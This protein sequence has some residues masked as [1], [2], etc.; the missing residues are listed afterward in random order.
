MYPS[1]NRDAAVFDDPDRFDVRRDPNPHLAFGFGPH[2]CLGASLARLELKV[3]FAELLRRLPD[4]AA[5]RR[6]ARPA[7]RRTSSRAPKRCRSR[8]PRHNYSGWK[9]AIVLPS[10]SLNQAE[11]PMP[12]EVTTWSTVLNVPVSY[13]SN[14]MP[15]RGELG[16]VLVDVGRPE[17]HLGVVGPVAARRGRRSAGSCRRRSRR[18]GGS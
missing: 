2:F 1:A 6:P 15:L 8:S 18:P 16:D 9:T 11:R 17:A 14:S 3:M 13:S 4:L 10:G 5:R 7:A 12:G